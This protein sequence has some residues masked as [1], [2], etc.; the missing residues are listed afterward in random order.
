VDIPRRDHR[1]DAVAGRPNGADKRVHRWPRLHAR[2][3]T[4]IR[5]HLPAAEDVLDPTK[6]VYDYPRGALLCVPSRGATSAVRERH[7]SRAPR[8]RHRRAEAFFRRR[9]T[10]GQTAADCW[11]YC[12]AADTPDRVCWRWL[13]TPVPHRWTIQ[14]DWVRRTAA[15]RTSRRRGLPHQLRMVAPR[16]AM[17]Y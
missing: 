12:T 10:R 3:L 8:R 7:R 1:V 2:I 13:F 16:E 5:E 15:Q 11:W 9:R 14:R 17:G 6:P 4:R